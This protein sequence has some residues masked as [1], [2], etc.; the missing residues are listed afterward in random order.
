MIDNNK[1]FNDNVSF[2]MNECCK[3]TCQYQS[4]IQDPLNKVDF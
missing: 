4:Q 1:K 2:N 3:R